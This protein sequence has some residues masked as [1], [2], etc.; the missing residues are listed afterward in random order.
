M[1]FY[2]FRHGETVW[3]VQ[4]IIKGYMDDSK[5]MFTE[6]GH[7]HMKAVADILSETGIQAIFASDLH[8]TSETARYISERLELPLFF[9]PRFRCMNSGIFQ[10]MSIKEFMQKEEVQAAFTDHDRA[11]P[12]G[13]SINQLVERFCGGL[14]EIRDTC[15]YDKVLVISHGASIS[16]VFS[17]INHSPFKSIDYCVLKTDGEHFLTTGSGE[18][19]RLL[20]EADTIHLRQE[21]LNRMKPDKTVKI[22]SSMY[23]QCQDGGYGRRQK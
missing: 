15:S 18:Y 20:K 23:H 2:L 3:N 14:K 10:G 5:N 11:F 4:G 1:V 6:A 9:S 22:H 7:A 21:V 8:R 13:E 16:N 19:G 17:K 12:G